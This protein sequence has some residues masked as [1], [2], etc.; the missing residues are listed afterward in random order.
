MAKS[1]K[2]IDQIQILGDWIMIEPE[3]ANA[4][5]VTGS[6]FYLTDRKVGNK[7][8][9]QIPKSGFVRGFG[10]DVHEDF[11]V[12]DRVILK[13]ER[14]NGVRLNAEEGYLMVKPENIIA[15]VE[16]DEHIS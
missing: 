7:T 11:A 13:L 16:G 1:K 14:V 9:H 3:L 15:R 4:A 12:G 8:V 10:P 2:M 6:G 5:R